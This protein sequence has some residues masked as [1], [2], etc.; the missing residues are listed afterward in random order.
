MAAPKK[1][2]TAKR[3]GMLSA[4]TAALRK[5]IANPLNRRKPSGNEAAAT[6]NACASQDPVADVLERDLIP[7][8]MMAHLVDGTMRPIEEHVEIDADETRRFVNLTLRVEAPRLLEEVD[9]FLEQG[10]SVEEICVDLLAPAARHLGGMWEADECDFVDVTMGLWRLQ[11]IMREISLRSPPPNAKTEL[12]RSA[13]FCPIPGDVHSFGAQM[14][15][16][17]FA[18][19][20]WQSEVLLKPQRRELLDYIAR[21]PINLLGL[22]V[23]RESPVSAISS[24]IR[25]VRSVAVNPQLKVMVGGH[26]IN[27]N[28]NLVAEIGADGT[29]IDARDALCTAEELVPTALARPH[30]L[31]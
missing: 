25:A 21:K 18:R 27:E 11:E 7:R 4:G 28:A 29:G 26:A 3:G 24:L 31:V 17:V 8:L 22:T 19:A 5:V 2:K 23:S 9:R 10:V 12:A 16:E 1:D 13:L 30:S 15:E 14:I 6:F 20:G